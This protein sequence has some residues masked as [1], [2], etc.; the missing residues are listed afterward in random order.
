MFLTAPKSQRE[1]MAG[2]S[3][4]QPGHQCM[5]LT[6]FQTH[7]PLSLQL[8]SSSSLPAAGIC[9]SLLKGPFL[10]MFI[11]YP[12][13]SVKVIYHLRPILKTFPCHSTVC[14]RFGTPG[15]GSEQGGMCTLMTLVSH[16]SCGVCT[17][18]R[19]STKTGLIPQNPQWAF[20]ICPP[21]L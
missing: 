2:P 8:G 7:G 6:S 9:C 17:H 19:P 13:L 12:S 3:M 21:P 11:Y 18:S 20:F 10:D 16:C 5:F 4:W 15:S 14:P 1:I